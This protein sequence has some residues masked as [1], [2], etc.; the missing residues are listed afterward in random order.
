MKTEAEP[1][2]KKKPTDRERASLKWTEAVRLI[3]NDHLP[4]EVDAELRLHF[5]EQEL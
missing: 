5:S 2:G 1:R 3:A 4:D